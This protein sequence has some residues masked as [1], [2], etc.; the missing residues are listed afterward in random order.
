MVFSKAGLTQSIR[1]AGSVITTRLL[2]E[3]ATMESLLSSSWYAYSR[4]TSRS[5][6]TTPPLEIGDVV[7]T[8]RTMRPSG[9]SIRVAS[10]RCSLALSAS[11][12]S[13]RDRQS[14]GKKLPAGRP[15]QSREARPVS[16][17]QAGFM[18]TICPASSVSITA[19]A[20]SSTRRRM[21]FSD[22]TRASMSRLVAS[23]CR[24]VASE[25][26]GLRSLGHRS[27]ALPAPPVRRGCWPSRRAGRCWSRPDRTA[28]TRSRRRTGARYRC[29]L[30]CSRTRS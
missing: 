30:T 28:G 19:S 24:S 6:A 22:S 5:T 17:S 25:L 23:T 21:R 16:D 29:A 4:L 7:R 27:S 8:T 15:R 1:P 18:K 10:S 12:S 11:T 20:R 3:L 13:T 26:V 9:C 14:S 2:V